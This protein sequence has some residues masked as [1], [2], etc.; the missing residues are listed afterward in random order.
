MSFIT[1]L[2]VET[3]IV[4]GHWQTMQFHVF[5]FIERDY[6]QLW[7][8]DRDKSASNCCCLRF[9]MLNVNAGCKAAALWKIIRWPQHLI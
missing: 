4:F 8:S 6:S 9:Q 5:F 7:I 1:R 3:L 2:A